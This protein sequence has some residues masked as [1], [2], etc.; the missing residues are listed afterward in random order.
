[1]N[2]NLL[3]IEAIDD[4]DNYEDVEEDEQPQMNI[5]VISILV[6]KWRVFLPRF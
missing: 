5:I 4:D 2:D 6:R 3:K 1:M